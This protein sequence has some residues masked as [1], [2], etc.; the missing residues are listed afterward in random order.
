SW[1][2]SRGNARAA[3]VQ[4]EA[5]ELSHRQTRIREIRRTAYLDFIE[6][7]HITG[8][9]Y[10]RLGDVYAKLSDDDDRLAGIQQLRSHLRDAF[11]PLMRSARLVA[12]EGPAAVAEAA[13]AVRHAA[14]GAN[15]AM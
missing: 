9:L 15:G 11:D 13:E 5:S 1:V 14:L 8:E 7:A 6:Q 10:F 2:T 4:A 12:L 3:R